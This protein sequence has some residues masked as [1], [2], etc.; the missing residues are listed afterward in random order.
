[1]PPRSRTLQSSFNAGELDPRLTARTDTK[2][3]YSGVKQARN[4]LLLPQ[5][6]V[7]RRPG[8]RHV[9]TLGAAGLPHQCI[10]FAFSI[11]QTYAV[12]LL[13]GGFRVFR[14]DGTALASVFGLPWTGQQAAEMNRAQSADTLLLVHPDLPP[15]RIRR[16]SDDSNWSCDT[17]GFS[18][19]PCHPFGR[20]PYS[21]GIRATPGLGLIP[22]NGQGTQPPDTYDV[23]ESRDGR[24][25]VEIAPD[26]DDVFTSDHIGWQVAHA[27]GRARIEAVFNGKQAAVYTLSEFIDGNLQ[28]P[29][30]LEEPIMSAARGYPG[31]ITFHQGRLYLGGFRSLPASMAGSVVGDFFNFDGR[32]ALADRGVAASIDSDQ[33]NAIHQ[34]V[35]ARNLQVLTAGSELAFTGSPPI[36]PANF[37]LAEQTR[38]GSKPH[39]RTA[40]LDGGT[41]FVQRN[42]AALRQFIY[43]DLVQSWKTELVSLLAPHLI[44]DPVD[45]AARK[46][47]RQDDADYVMLVN[48]DGTLTVLNLLREQEIAGFSLWATNGAFRRICALPSGEVFITAER[49][50]ALRLESWDEAA[51]T[52]A[53]VLRG[54]T[55]GAVTGLEHLEGQTVQLVLDGA[56]GGTAVVA[57]GRVNLPRAATALVEIG[58]PFTPRIET[59]PPEPALPDGTAIGRKVRIISAT[60]R[61]QDT[62]PFTV[63]GVLQLPHKVGQALDTLPPRLT[64]DIKLRG[65]LGWQQRPT[66]TIEQ[67]DAAPFTLLGLSLEVDTGA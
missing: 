54:P 46:A 29:W 11:D 64:G 57:A 59:M 16:G 50:G 63:N 67:P 4:V 25:F 55:S 60:A 26:G 44:R 32:T 62:G 61:V 15:Q 20:P 40:E 19:L 41:L 5:G 17:P 7:R 39:V 34:L 9:T 38:R 28:S 43:E 36:T 2:K 53:A 45:L 13:A 49:G 12:V 14:P 58:L 31:S 42:G 65:L 10:A 35:S 27:D 18:N 33:I 6:G 23:T 66:I 21:F 52:D 56:M 24:M 30:T 22:W 48:S 1:M 37:F 47:A 8:L 3:Y 51:L